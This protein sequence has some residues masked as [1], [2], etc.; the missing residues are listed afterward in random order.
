M[1]IIID[2]VENKFS[3]E[4]NLDLVELEEMKK[5]LL[6]KIKN[7]SL[8]SNNYYGGMLDENINKNTK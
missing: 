3:N 2:V 7:S 4:K 6:D 8:N 5:E 1:H